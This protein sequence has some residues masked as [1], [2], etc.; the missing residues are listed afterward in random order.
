MAGMEDD[1]ALARAEAFG[2]DLSLLRESLKLT[3][4][5]RLEYHEGVLE[6]AEA[7]RRAGEEKYGPFPPPDQ[8]PLPTER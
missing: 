5:E 4:T 3:P 2:I 1:P 8:R 6:F 7:L